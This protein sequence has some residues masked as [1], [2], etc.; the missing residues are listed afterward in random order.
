MP[1]IKKEDDKAGKTVKKKVGKTSSVKKTVRKKPVK[2]TA[3]S[4]SHSVSGPQAITIDVITDNEDVLFQAPLKETEEEFVNEDRESFDVQ[5][6]FFSDLVAEMKD[7]QQGK[8]LP[9]QASLKEEFDQGS[10]RK[11]LRLYRRM[12]IQSGVLTIFLLLLGGYFLLPSLKIFVRPN[13]ESV[14]DSLSF[15]VSNNKVQVDSVIAS[16]SRNLQG[17]VQILPINADKVYQASGEE[18][19]GEEVVGEVTIYNEYS[20]AQPLVINTRLL[21]EDNKLFRLKESVTIPASDSIK[22]EVYAD[23][24]GQEMAIGPSKFTI[25]GL[26][27]GLQDR[28]YARSEETFEYRHQVKRYV[29]Q[30]DLD[31]A[32]IDIKNTLTKESESNIKS[33]QSTN[34]EVAY[35]L[36]NNSMEIDLGAKLGEEVDDFTVSAKNNL[37]I[38]VFPKDQAEALI[39]AKLSFLMPEDKRLNDF[40]KSTIVYRLDAYDQED[41]S[42]SISASFKANMSLRSDSEIIDRRQ[43]VGLNQEQIAEYLRSFPEIDSYRLEFFP[44]FIK[45]APILPDRIKVEVVN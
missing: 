14:A 27:L 20:R 29:K 28:I 11:P 24:P 17:E 3:P 1:K 45:N 23:A 13:F 10:P 8:D 41:E 33:L 16:S 22:V 40:E 25:P 42:A 30:N 5:K 21:S 38:A 18:I 35:L 26:W 6:K 9:L 37:V 34:Q 36:D 31:Q 19:L 2:K 43:L 7:K 44:A 15:R 39:K 32:M 12:A 4:S